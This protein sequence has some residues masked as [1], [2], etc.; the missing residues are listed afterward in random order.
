MSETNFDHELY[1]VEKSQLASAFGAV[2]QAD[3]ISE[4]EKA[5]IRRCLSNYNSMLDASKEEDNSPDAIITRRIMLS[6][7]LWHCMTDLEEVIKVLQR[8]ESY[9]KDED[10]EELNGLISLIN[11]FDKD[12]KKPV[13]KQ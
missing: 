8:I 9:C 12:I 1:L 11:Q 6:F 3:N 13:N 2:E 7:K 4:D 5:V 10:K